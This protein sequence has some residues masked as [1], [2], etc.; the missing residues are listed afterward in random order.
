L[1]RRQLADVFN[2]LGERETWLR[3]QAPMSPAFRSQTV[4]DLEDLGNREESTQRD[5]AGR[6][7]VELLQ[8]AH[9]ACSDAQ[10]KGTVR[11]VVTDSALLVANQGQPFDATR[12]RSL[13]RQGT[14][15]KAGRRRK[16]TIGYKGVGFSSVFEI[17]QTPQI[18]SADGYAFGFDRARAR[19]LVHKHLRR[20][21][22]T[23]AARNFPFVIDADA[24][25]NDRTVIQALLDAGFVTIVRL[26]MRKGWGPSTVFEH[27]ID[28]F[29]AETLVFLPS[30]NRLECQYAG[31]K[32]GWSSHPG[33]RSRHGRIVHVDADSAERV[34]WLVRSGTVQV[35]RDLV[36]ALEDPAWRDVG[37]VR[38]TVGL[39][40]AGRRVN[41][42]APSV[43]VHV[44]FPTSETTGRS[45][46]IHG[47]FV[48]DSSR[49]QILLDGPAGEINRMAARGVAGLV[50][51]LAESLAAT[52]AGEVLS[53]LGVTG[54]ASDYGVLL[55][56]ALI[57]T[58]VKARIGRPAD[59]GALVPLSQLAFVTDDRGSELDERLM[60]IMS[61]R[62]DLM[63]VSDTTRDRAVTLA[64]ELGVVGL[65]P[66]ATAA[67][68][69]LHNATKLSY[70][71]GL[72]LLDDWLHELSRSEGA[73][74][75]KTLR[76]RRI[77]KRV[78]GRWYAPTDAVLSGSGIPPLPKALRLA[79]VV[80]VKAEA[81]RDLLEQLEVRRLDAA[82]ALALVGDALEAGQ[83]GRND[84]ERLL[85]HDWLLALWRATPRAFTERD[86]ALHGQAPVPAQTAGGESRGWEPASRVYFGGGRAGPGPHLERLYGPDGRRE[87]LIPPPSSPPGP[88]AFYRALGVA[89]MPRSLP[90]RP[91]HVTRLEEW[92]QL[93]EVITASK[94][95]SGDQ[96]TASNQKL[97]VSVWDRL[98]QILARACA[99]EE[100]SAALAE[101]LLAVQGEPYGP[102]AAYKCD[103]S[104]HRGKAKN[105]TAIG[106]Q[107]WRMSNSPWMTV[108]QDPGGAERRPPSAAWCK[109]PQSTRALLLPR[110]AKAKLSS[111]AFGLVSWERPDVEDV[112]RALNDLHEA[113]RDLASAPP[114]ISETADR[115][116]QRLET[117]L[118]DEPAK[119]ETV[120][121][122]ANNDG[123]RVW[124]WAHEAYVAD[125]PNLQSIEGLPV[126]KIG[127]NSRVRRAYELQLLS[128]A[129]TQHVHAGAAAALSRLLPLERRV[130]LLVLL[131]RAGA[132]RREAAH[133]LATLHEK[134]VERI[135]L[136]LTIRDLP[137]Q[138]QED[139]PFA[140]VSS[141]T[142]ADLYVTSQT[143]ARRLRL[144][145]VLANYL[146]LGDHA[147]LIRLMLTAPDELSEDILDSERRDA[148]TL[149][150]GLEDEEDD[151]ATDEE[152][153]R[154]EGEPKS[155]ESAVD[156]QDAHPVHEQVDRDVKLAEPAGSESPRDL[157]RAPATER[158]WQEPTTGGD[159]SEGAPGQPADLD[160]RHSGRPSNDDVPSTPIESAPLV[161]DQARLQ[162]GPPIRA[163]FL[164]LAASGPA[165]HETPPG[166][167]REAIPRAFETPTSAP[168]SDEQVERAA[169]ETVCEYARRELD[170]TKIIDRGPTRLE[171]AVHPG[172]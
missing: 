143:R 115:L 94:C 3:E 42:E 136:E 12:L 75:I 57:E 9:D 141:D 118:S 76:Q 147:Q 172:Y 108:V 144:A 128:S 171:R 23:V 65:E 106:Y 130:N 120:P 139:L 71:K 169:V 18:I 17:S 95:P 11:F 49:S 131:E 151:L 152:T 150:A 33:H 157:T 14:S 77:L 109:M 20:R 39:P 79:E 48:M 165:K 29:V 69:T 117:A 50:L 36:E 31:E 46:L 134:P 146:D 135:D 158:R 86:P 90:A 34:S 140:L 88:T 112:E 72:V 58:L 35:D 97:R 125:I 7:P 122:P 124:V 163:E 160:R 56:E 2:V 78:D 83:F 63:R 104:A 123:T 80:D 87:F 45:C 8:N 138:W 52:Q 68:V 61:K 129:V 53:A 19:A 41:P 142:G 13:V 91:P 60:A 156:R 170:V 5:Y 102:A 6:Y 62:K 105:R 132:D 47:D 98:D 167:E 161:V 22:T 111:T 154:V 37:E 114:I 55:N 24:W 26:P 51:E 168:R 4:R 155:G 107:A 84:A 145:D 133:R 121:L 93:P 10:I 43:P 16:R 126:A 66:E 1:N 67:R 99:S 70:E 101:L 113:H 162:F 89:E 15:E 54:T 73:K 81:A 149:L 103:H 159:S 38:L 30:V 74:V 64:R 166:R 164:E 116:L 25:E 21:V 153:S 148:A 127:L 40:W 27:I 119:R 32:S 92:K 28:Q 110:P 44:Y 100:D 85:L 96:H 82:A 137:T 59:G